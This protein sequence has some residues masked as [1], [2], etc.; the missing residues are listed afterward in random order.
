MRWRECRKKA[1]ALLFVFVLMILPIGRHLI[2]S[3]KDEGKEIGNKSISRSQE[4]TEKN[5]RSEEEKDKADTTEKDQKTDNKDKTD[6]KSQ[7]Q[8]TDNNDKNKTNQNSDKNDKEKTSQSSDK[9]SKNET[10][11]NSD[12]KGK[13]ETSQSSDKKDDKS[14]NQNASGK[15]D[16][17]KDGDAGTKDHTDSD[18]KNENET[19]KKQDDKAEEADFDVGEDRSRDKNDSGLK[20]SEGDGMQAGGDKADGDSHDSVNEKDEA[21]RLGVKAD[22]DGNEQNPV[23]NNGDGVNEKKNDT[24]GIKGTADQQ[25]DGNK[26]QDSEDKEDQPGNE[27]DDK[28]YPKITDFSIRSSDIYTKDETKWY[29]AYDKEKGRAHITFFVSSS[30]ENLS[31]VIIKAVDKGKKKEIKAEKVKGKDGEFSADFDDEGSWEFTAFVTNEKGKTSSRKLGDSSDAVNVVISNES[32][33]LHVSYDSVPYKEKDSYDSDDTIYYGPGQENL[34][35]RISDE[36]ASFAEDAEEGPDITWN[37]TF[38]MDRKETIDLEDTEYRLSCLLKEEGSCRFSI[39][40]RSKNGR[41]PLVTEFFSNGSQVSDD[42]EKF[43][44]RLITIDHTPPELTSL[45]VIEGNNRRYSVEGRDCIFMNNASNEEAC[46]EFTFRESHLASSAASVMSG[47]GEVDLPAAVVSQQGG[48][49][50]L[51]CRFDIGCWSN[52]EEGQYTLSPSEIKDKAGNVCL[53]TGDQISLLSSLRIVI[54][55]TAPV[56]S[57]SYQEP[58]MKI[59]DSARFSENSMEYFYKEKPLVRIGVKEDNFIFGISDDD[60]IMEINSKETDES[61]TY[62][63][64]TAEGLKFSQEENGQWSCIFTDLPDKEAHSYFSLS[65]VDPSGN[66]ALKDGGGDDQGKITEREGKAFYISPVITVDNT[67]PV[68]S[69]SFSAA[70]T[71]E[72]G[73]RQYFQKAVTMIITVTD[74]NFMCKGQGT[75]SFR[76][77]GSTFDF[78][79]ATEDIEEKQFDVSWIGG[80]NWDLGSYHDGKKQYK[81]ELILEEEWNYVIKIDAADLSGNKSLEKAEEVTVDTHKP[82]ISINDKENT[83]EADVQMLGNDDGKKVRF[84][85][86]MHYGYFY[87]N[88]IRV[89]VTAHDM[90]AGVSAIRFRVTH[91]DGKIVD[92][93]WDFDSQTGQ[94]TKYL[95]I[96]VDLKARIQLQPV[97]FGNLAGKEV[98]PRGIV[99]ES[100]DWHKKNSSLKVQIKTSPF[101]TVGNLKYFNGPVEVD[102]SINDSHSGIEK[103]EYEAGKSLSGKNDYGRQVGSSDREGESDKEITYSCL[104]HLTLPAGN[105][106]YSDKNNPTVIKASFTDHAGYEENVRE[107]IVIDDRKPEIDVVWTGLEETPDKIHYRSERTAVIHVREHNFDESLVTWKIKNKSGIHISTWQHKGDDHSCKVVFDKDGDD[108]LLDFDVTDLSGNKASC[109]QQKTFC[110]DKTPPVITLSYDNNSVR[111]KKYYNNKRM[112]TITVAEHSFRASDVKCSFRAKYQSGNKDIYSPSSWTGNG[113]IHKNVVGC[114]KDGEYTFE[115]DYTDLAGNHAKTKITDSF[116]IDQTPP[117]V[118]ITGVKNGGVYNNTVSPGVEYRDD[119]LVEES[120]VIRLYGNKNGRLYHS[121]SSETNL[122]HGKKIRWKDFKR[123]QSTDDIYTL[124]VMVEDKAGNRNENTGAVFTVDRFGSSY[125]LSKDTEQLVNGDNPYITEPIPIDVT[126]VN[127]CSLKEE[128]VTIRNDNNEIIALRQGPDYG[129]EKKQNQ[130]GWYEYT[131]HIKKENFAN[132]GR[133]TVTI[134]SVDEADNQMTNVSKDKQVRFVVDQTMPYGVITGLEEKVYKEN[135]HEIVIRADDNYALKEAEL[136]VNGMKKKTYTPDDFLYGAGIT[137]YLDQSK[138]VQKVSLRLVDKAGNTRTVLPRGNPFGSLITTSRFVLVTQQ[139]P[140]IAFAIL[141]LIAGLSLLTWAL[142]KRK[143]M[144]R[145]G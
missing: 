91:E 53:T 72:Y 51:R 49:I 117:L 142:E 28:D 114:V 32:P 62:D 76:V 43:Q 135:R 77:V 14:Q 113:D 8:D 88:T 56:L 143:N 98:S 17:D 141:I 46:I 75:D 115:I 9:K 45:T 78:D 90:T 2:V 68:I 137:E 123:N 125:T 24:D 70:P 23:G 5:V 134:A 3:A 122:I 30:S 94:Q 10:S 39:S 107:N 103:Y 22:E 38:S 131:Y 93:G 120:A 74:E 40:Y 64:A 111:N 130:Y 7:A 83:D 13:D 31:N 136:Y 96:P 55:R 29:V 106:N 4:V 89:K 50:T 87:R 18:K 99:T 108:Y 20:D 34:E 11:Q 127:V 86:Y 82:Y 6:Q 121:W 21:S 19:G 138:I 101:R 140:Y 47:N 54:D 132:E 139:I 112:A 79:S 60:M 25:G 65:F 58:E 97:D 61:T 69:T 15:D 52:M 118:R 144:E 128:S 133:Y 102:I 92:G 37:T 145:T 48:S 44:S 116:I 84:Y 109:P 71:G 81:A 104:F 66:R 12:K 85:D 67:E 95:T 35:I 16:K 36:L 129:L 1:I 110:V 63:I 119:N 33:E 80:T 126:E 57:V 59:E 124:M 27:E 100:Y 41:T 73:R 105:V 26:E 42:K